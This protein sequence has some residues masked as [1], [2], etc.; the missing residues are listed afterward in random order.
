[1]W[2]CFLGEKPLKFTPGMVE[3]GAQ[4]EDWLLGAYSVILNPCIVPSGQRLLAWLCLTLSHW[5]KRHFKTKGVSSKSLKSPYHWGLFFW[6][7]GARPWTDLAGTIYLQV[8]GKILQKD[9]A[10][11]LMGGMAGIRFGGGGT[12]MLLPTSSGFASN[13]AAAFV[14]FVVGGWNPSCYS[15]GSIEGV[16][17]VLRVP[18]NAS[19]DSAAE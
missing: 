11:K 2:R 6:S 7:M 17:D 12:S 14:A 13:P 4:G 10:L 15:Q 19:P 18:A 16:P 8:P 1:M 9:T 3:S 5:P